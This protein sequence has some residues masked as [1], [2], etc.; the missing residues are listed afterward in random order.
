MKAIV[1]TTTSCAFCPGVK[2]YLK[3]KGVDYIE[4]NA[5]EPEILK[6]AMAISGVARVP[7][8]FLNGKVVVGPNFGQ[9]AEAIDA[10]V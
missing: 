7:I 9:L 1:Y 6:E 3:S 4:K 10:P 5:E 2:K 8:T